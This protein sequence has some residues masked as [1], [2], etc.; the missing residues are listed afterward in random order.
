MTFDPLHC[1]PCFITRHCPQE[2]L[3]VHIPDSALVIILAA[4]RSIGS[5]RSWTPLVTRW[6]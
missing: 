2:S 5:L 1:C 4:T 6:M 3:R